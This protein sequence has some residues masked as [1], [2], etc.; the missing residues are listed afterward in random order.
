MEAHD[1]PFGEDAGA[2]ALVDGDGG[3]VPVEDVPFE[4]GAALLDG[5]L[6]EAS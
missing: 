5:D 4:A 2:E 3:G 1:A 6:R